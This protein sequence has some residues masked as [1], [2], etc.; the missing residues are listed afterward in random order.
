LSACSTGANQAARLADESIILVGVLQLAGF[1]HMVGTLWEV[2]ER[3]FV[4]VVR[5]LYEII[6]LHTSLIYL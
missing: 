4:D 5:G 2:S 6:Y 1:R 3:H